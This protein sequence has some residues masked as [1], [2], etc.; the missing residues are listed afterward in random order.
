MIL[1]QILAPASEPLITSVEVSDTDQETIEVT[2]EAV[3]G[4]KLHEF[5][6]VRV[7]IYNNRERETKLAV[8]HQ[9]VRAEDSDVDKER[10][11]APRFVV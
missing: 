4:V 8:H 10:K 5:Y 7:Y 9:L 3:H 11:I 6:E 2:S 1:S